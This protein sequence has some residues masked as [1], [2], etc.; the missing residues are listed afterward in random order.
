MDLEI[1]RACEERLVNVWPAVSTLLMDGWVVRFAHGYSGRA[2]SASAVVPGA[3]MPEPLLDTIEQL[4]DDAG[5]PPSVRVTPLAGPDVEPLLL[6]RGYR[7][8]DQSRMMILPLERYRDIAPDPRVR[9]E[10]APSRR[11]LAGVS[12]HQEPSKRSAD[13]LFAIVGHLRVP[14]AFATLEIEGKAVGFGMGAIDRGYA[15]IG[16]IMLDGAW[17]G[18]GLGRATVDALLAWAARQDAALAFLQVDATNAA[19]RRLYAS[20]GFA[21]LCG[22]KTMIRDGVR[23]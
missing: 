19:A 16:S 1:V 6:R 11:W 7:I 12:S 5:L 20:Q 22:Y 8:K 10:G 2:N 3:L 13:H 17:R 4:Y 23:S 9:L 14:A 21:D 15:E 18:Q